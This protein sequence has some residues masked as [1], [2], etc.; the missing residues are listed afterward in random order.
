ME[1]S[2]CVS[3]PK[4]NE[5]QADKHIHGIVKV[6]TFVGRDWYII[7]LK[8]SAEI[9]KKLMSIHLEMRN[10]ITQDLNL[11]GQVLFGVE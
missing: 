10:V 11:I 1:T 9:E 8:F 6:V 5:R 2:G 4:E 7:T 3:T